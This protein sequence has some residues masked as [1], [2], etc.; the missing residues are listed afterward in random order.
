ML[1]NN[2]SRLIAR[3]LLRCG[4]AFLW[5]PLLLLAA[6]AKAE[7]PTPTPPPSGLYVDI[8]KSYEEAAQPA[9]AAEFYLK[10]LDADPTND[11]ALAALRSIL[12]K[13]QADDPR[14]LIADQYMAARQYDKAVDLYLKILADRPGLAEAQQSAKT[15]IDRSD[16]LS[17]QTIAE[18]NTVGKVAAAGLALIVFLL[19]LWLLARLIR[20]LRQRRIDPK[21]VEYVILPF[22]NAT[23]VPGLAGVQEG[24]RAALIEW[25][26]TN[27][28]VVADKIPEAPVPITLPEAGTATKIFNWFAAQ[29]T[30]TP[31]R[32][33]VNGTLQGAR[34]TAAG[35]TE[36]GLSVRVS[37]ARGGGIERTHTI[38]GEAASPSDPYVYLELAAGA[39]SWIVEPGNALQPAPALQLGEANATLV[40]AKLAKEAKDYA[41]GKALAAY[42][43]QQAKNADA[44]EN[45]LAKAPVRVLTGAKAPV[46]PVASTMASTRA[47]LAEK[48]RQSIL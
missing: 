24:A 16:D 4:I 9:K 12:Q 43:V 5:I 26:Q 33:V 3:R 34:K 2:R 7:T 17:T 29:T 31:C 15:A 45:Q 19:L 8:G 21:K 13:Q 40:Q 46:P 41:K 22:E 32:K 30:P 27:H 1:S 38:W 37:D 48:Y 39:A 44:L 23:G 6:I 42:A 25:L 10:A 20:R 36:A 28:A 14:L 18:A 35:T 47:E 11:A